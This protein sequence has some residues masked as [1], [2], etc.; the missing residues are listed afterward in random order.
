MRLGTEVNDFGRITLCIDV[1]PAWPMAGLALQ[2]AVSERT[3]RIVRTCVLGVE[4]A[5]DGGIVVAP[6]AGIGSVRAVGRGWRR[7][8]VG[9]KRGCDPRCHHAQRNRCEVAPNL[10]HSIA[11]GGGG[12]VV[13]D[14]DIRNSARTVTH[15]A[16]LDVRRDGAENRST[17]RVFRDRERTTVLLH[18]GLRERIHM[19]G[20]AH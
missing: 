2:T 3:T 14:L 16:G 13:H 4:D 20:R 8:T 5:R 19:T 12:H 18:V 7:R 9:S 10:S 15:A 17:L 6:E 1:G 11:R